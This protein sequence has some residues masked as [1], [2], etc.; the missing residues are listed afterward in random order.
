M[1]YPRALAPIRDERGEP[2][3]DA[4]AAFGLAQEKHTA[5]RGQAPTIEPGYDLAALDAWQCERQRA[6]VVHGGWARAGRPRGIGV[7]TQILRCIK[8]LS[9]TRQ[10]RSTALMNNSGYSQA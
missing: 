5:I 4:Q 3:G 1:R 9:Y 7:D 6:I 8:C 2:V 10:P